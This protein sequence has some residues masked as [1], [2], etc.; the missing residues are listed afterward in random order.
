[1]IENN[2]SYIA[3]Y[4]WQKSIENIDTILTKEEKSR[5]NIADYYY[6]TTIYHMDYPT[7]GE[8]SEK[9][10]F[11]KPAISAMVKR[12]E[13]LDFIE[14]HQSSIDKRIYNLLITEKGKNIVEGDN[15]LYQQFTEKVRELTTEDQM[16]Q[17][18]CLL[19]KLTAQLK[20]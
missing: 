13:G 17:F 3:N 16:K 14:K 4:L 1:M 5:F 6:L 20:E 11:T 9:L 8:V 18:T 19:E 10:S 7:L 15:S 12:L 2:I